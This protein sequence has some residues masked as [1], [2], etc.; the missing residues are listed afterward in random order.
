MDNNSA[1]ILL[2]T[3][4]ANSIVYM[5]VVHDTTVYR[6]TRIILHYTRRCTTHVAGL[7]N[8]FAY[9]C[10]VHDATVSASTRI[11]L[12]YTCMCVV[13][14]TTVSGSTRIICVQKI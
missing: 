6:S 4:L 8:S 14:D 3:C 11:I 2:H 10:A 5:C 1:T 12:H 13:H 9:M 7:D